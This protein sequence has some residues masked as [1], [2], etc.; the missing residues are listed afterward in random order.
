MSFEATSDES[1][2][3]SK[4]PAELPIRPDLPRLLLNPRIDGVERV[5][6]DRPE[7]A[8]VDV[9]LALFF[10]VQGPGADS[11]EDADLVA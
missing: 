6:A 5:V 7:A 8:V 3:G 1:S 11:A 2:N 9:H 4:S 10:S